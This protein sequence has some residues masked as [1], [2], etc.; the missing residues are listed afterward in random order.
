MRSWSAHRKGQACGIQHQEG[1]GVQPMPRRG[2]AS[3]NARAWR[4]LAK[5]LRGVPRCPQPVLPEQGQRARQTGW[6]WVELE[7]EG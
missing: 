2:T 6:Q 1:E 5:R 7:G 3:G 4:G